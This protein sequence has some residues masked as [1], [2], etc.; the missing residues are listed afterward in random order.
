M[1]VEPITEKVWEC[2]PTMGQPCGVYSPTYCHKGCV[3][4]TGSW[5]VPARP[6][7][8]KVDGLPVG[9]HGVPQNKVGRCTRPSEMEKFDFR[10]KADF[11]MGKCQDEEEERNTST[12]QE[13]CIKRLEQ[14]IEEARSWMAFN[15]VKLNDEKTE[16]IA[17]GT[18]QQ[19]D[20]IDEISITVGLGFIKPVKFV[21]IR[22]YFT[23]CFMKNANHINWLTSIIFVMLR[24]IR[25]TRHHLDKDTTKIL[26]QVLVMSKLE[27]CNSPLVGSAEYQLDK[28]QCIQNMACRVVCKLS[29]YDY[30]SGYMADLHWLQVHEC[31]KYKFAVIKFRNK[32]NTTLIYI[33]E[34]LP[35]TKCPRHLRSSLSGYITPTFC[36]HP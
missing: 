3:Y 34:L 8:T 31:I 17:F 28:L 19:L 21:W 24:D 32:D 7:K 22:A 10:F 33:K 6:T 5:E 12:P 4:I 26:I 13:T 30:I 27:Y 14:C 9:Q 20:K 25:A 35:P 16:F 2:L 1:R 29:K 23:D 11:V 15:L 18:S 36:K